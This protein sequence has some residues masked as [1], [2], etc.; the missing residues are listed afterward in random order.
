M[1]EMRKSD[2][3]VLLISKCRERERERKRFTCEF[4]PLE[5]RENC[6]VG[7]KTAIFEGEKIMI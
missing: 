4:R 5:G 6:S 3:R 7:Q 2:I 1:G